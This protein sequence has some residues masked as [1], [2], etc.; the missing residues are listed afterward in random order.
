[1]SLLNSRYARVLTIVLLL[2]GGVYYAVA[3]RSE[4]TPPVRPLA[5]FPGQLPDWRVTQEFPIEQ[6]VQEVLKADDMLSREYTRATDSS[7]IVLFIGFFKTQRY[8]QSPH[9]PKNCLPGAGFE[10]IENTT[11]RIPVEGRN[12][13]IE[14]NKYV[15]ERGDEKSVT[16]YWYQGH[17]RVIASEYWAKYWLV[18]DAVKMRR[19]DTSIVKVVINVQ[20]NRFD[21]ATKIGVDFIKVMFP[22][23]STTLPS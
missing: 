10:P 1:V 14:I 6:E 12:T 5:L 19:S 18:L 17:N 9:S 15:T 22:Y 3:S 20:N 21:D 16:L 13:P 2:Q 4:L 11:I 7:Q 23:L 8:G